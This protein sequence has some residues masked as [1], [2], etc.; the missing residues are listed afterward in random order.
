M[1]RSRFSEEQI[2]G[3]LREVESGEKIKAV[4]AKLNTAEATFVG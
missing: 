1:R 4:C 3:I 2:T